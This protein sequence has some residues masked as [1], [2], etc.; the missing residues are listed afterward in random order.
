MEK[1]RNAIRGIDTFRSLSDLYAKDPGDIATVFKLAQKYDQRFASSGKADQLYRRVVALDPEG[2][3]G[4][5]DVDYAKVRVP[6]TEFAEFILA[7]KK[8][9]GAEAGPAPMRAFIEKYP[10]SPLVKT[11]YMYMSNYYG[12][13]FDRKEARAFFEE[14]VARYPDS[15][16]AL[17]SYVRRIIRDKEPLDRGIELAERIA[18]LTSYNP[19]P[20]DTQN[21]AELYWLRGDKAKAEEILGKDFL[22]ARIS[23]A[24]YE[25]ANFASFW[26]GRE[27]HDEEAVEAIELAIKIR[28]DLPHLR[29]TAA[30][31][32]AKAG[33]PE[34][35]LDV[36]GPGYAKENR[37]RTDALYNYA[38]YWNRKGQN[39][40]SALEAIARVIE[41]QPGLTYFDLQAQILL[42]LKKY[43]EAL[44]SAERALALAKES[45]KRRAGFSIK[46]Y[47]ARA[48][49]I[50]AAMAG[51][52]K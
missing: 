10:R 1:I 24:A 6:Y 28:P 35:A 37:D 11:G 45:A 51:D 25:L 17:G 42:K 30:E 13:C 7:R 46:P 52:K 2:K 32:Y 33:R 49:E 19:D 39:L 26:S 9:V 22:K 21:R 23:N 44:A 8:S 40:E 20:Y 14:F 12:S 31:I 47:E 27:T 43:G 15:A 3:A 38:W 50:K 18:E 5:V 16:E 34:K 48:Q 41:I 36:F 29:R 4:P